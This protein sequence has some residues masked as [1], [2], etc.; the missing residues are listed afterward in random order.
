[1]PIEELSTFISELA[2]AAG[3][4]AEAAL[5]LILATVLGG[6]IGLDREIRG[7]EAGFRTNILVCVGSA[8]AMIVSL[9]FA[10]QAWSTYP[11]PDQLR[12]DPG[13]I[14]YGVMAGVG[15]LGAGSIIHAR[16]AIRGITTASAIWTAAAIGLAAGFGLYLIATFAALLVLVVLTGLNLLA[17]LIP[18]RDQRLVEVRLPPEDPH[19]HFHLRDA[20]RD[21]GFTIQS[22]RFIRDE[23]DADPDAPRLDTA[24]FVIDSHK[25]HT[26]ERFD[27]LIADRPHHRLTRSEPAAA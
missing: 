20:V 27:Q 6:L 16:G 12:V 7:H 18:D 4:T 22:F 25:R 23:C 24:Q 17:R 5:R 26:L 2:G 19:A 8:L 1:M 10:Q 21:A 15:F 13:R 14:A 3:F 9:A 11:A